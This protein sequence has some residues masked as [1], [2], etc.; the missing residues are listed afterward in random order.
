MKQ[1]SGGI[2][3]ENILGASTLDTDLFP[4]NLTRPALWVA[5]FNYQ[6]NGTTYERVRGN[7]EETVL[8][9]AVRSA[10]N[11]SADSIN[12]NARGLYI[13][14]DITAVPGVQTVTLTVTGKDPVSGKYITLLTGAAEVAVA[15]KTYLVYPGAGAAANGVNVV[16]GFPLPRTWRVTIT[17][18]GAGNFTY[19]VGAMLIR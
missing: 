12:R 4:S 6:F 18:S 17:H 13:V 16:N 10:T 19:S 15:T 5:N 3:T 14:F 9:S 8:A 2:G 7:T 11:N 1:F